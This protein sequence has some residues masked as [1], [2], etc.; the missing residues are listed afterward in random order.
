MQRRRKKWITWI[1][2]AVAVVLLMILLWPRHQQSLSY[3]TAPASRGDITQQLTLV[4][5]V[6][7][8]G[9]AKVESS[10]SGMVTSVKVRVG[11]TVTAGQQ[12]AAIDPAD[13]RLALLQARA[14]LASAQAQ[15]DSDLAAKKAGAARK[16]ASPAAPLGAGAAAGA[17]T[18]GGTSGTLALPKAPVGTPGYVTDM[19]R[20]LAKL[21][22]VVKRQQQVCTPVLEALNRLKNSPQP[23]A[24]PTPAPTSSATPLP[25]LTPA[26]TTATPTPPITPE[27]MKK[28]LG[29]ADQV[30]AC[31][32]A[33]LAVATG[34]GAAGAAITTAVEG[35]AHDTQQATKALAAAQAQ[36]Q[37]AAKQAS[38]QA[39]KLAQAQLEK[40]IGASFG[41]S[42]SDASIAAARARLLQAQQGVERAETDLKEATITSPIAG[43]IGALDFA[44]GEPSSGKSAT[45]VGPGAVSI[46]VNVSLPDRPLVAPG[47]TA[48]VGHLATRPTLT[49]TV[50]A[51]G[52]LP[53]NSAGT[54][55]YPAL[56]SSDDPGQTL[57]E[58]SYAQVTLGL[59]RASDVLTVPMSAVTKTSENAGTVQVVSEKY[60][61]T[62]STVAVTTGR[63]GDGRIEITSGL[64]EGQLTVLADRRLPLPNGLGL[65]T[66]SGSGQGTPGPTPS[67]RPS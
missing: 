60:A 17:G 61:S 18:S 50:T 34:E 28:L 20:S 6:K 57:P 30:K 13:L 53:A 59:A 11:D 39:I 3:V 12:I 62:A 38:E 19:N 36:M 55:S 52:V 32:D 54:P 10:A 26:P 58:G 46:S 47:V 56:L 14:Q 21:Q 4:G 33:M 51:V 44:V 65:G 43:V 66:M 64:T 27:D 8:S 2:A 40:Q 45:V 23:T 35:F 1:G 7:R 37:Q 67:P 48:Q 41:G 49:G 29:M 24:T 31:S 5:Q 9:A 42:V 22:Q 63:Q 15:L 25:A 16:Q